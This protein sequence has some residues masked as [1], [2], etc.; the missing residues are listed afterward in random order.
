MDLRNL[1]EGDCG[2]ANPLIQLGSHFTRDA[3]YRDEGFSQHANTGPFNTAGAQDEMVKEFLGQV[4]SVP[5]T[6]HMDNLLQEMRAIEAQNLHQS[7]VKAPKVINEVTGQPDISSNWAND[8]KQN[9]YKP[10]I[11][12]SLENN[13]NQPSY[14]GMIAQGPR[15]MPA[16]FNNS[17]NL[18]MNRMAYSN[19]FAKHENELF[20]EKHEQS[21]DKVEAFF[22][23]TKEELQ[24]ANTS[25]NWLDDF[26]K[27]KQE[28]AE[29]AES[30]YDK[31]WTKLQQDWNDMAEYDNYP[32]LSQGAD[33]DPYK[34][35]EFFADNPMS[36]I[37]NPLEKGKEFL[38]QGDI[39]TAVLCFEA[40]VKQEPENV[41]AWEL[42]GLSQ[43]ENEMDPQAITALR[44]SLDI[45]PNNKTVLMALAVSYTNESL[46]SQALNM[47]AKWLHI[48]PK[49]SNL[50]PANLLE[51]GNSITNS[52]IGPNA[53]KD[54]Q[55]L[56]LE[57]V[58]Q[59]QTTV[60]PEIQE[61]LG[62]LFNL[63]SEYD[64][65]AD[66]FQAALSSN[67]NSSKTWNRLGASFANGNRSVEAVDAYKQAL[68]I[69]PGFIRAR[70][71][72]GII[73][74]N[75]KA[76]KE[77]AEHLLTALN[78]QA[79]SLSRS[80]LSENVTSRVSPMSEVIWSTLRM[81][82]ALMGR[83]DLK[84]AA[85]SRDLECLNHEIKVD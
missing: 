13:Y 81:V 21:S 5:Q 67:P 18:F 14:S 47:L 64:K 54:M 70:Y 61:A 85:H 60:D 1:L 74:M 24:S 34:E 23:P 27:N 6:F 84:K 59:N 58:K 37:E 31:F 71:N 52:L 82:F 30:Y 9:N 36:N 80:G 77:A 75:L 32:W 72:V 62:V 20:G 19:Q 55:N 2:G 76:Y 17:N 83:D 28:E 48:N 38:K 29:K 4:S 57:A 50:V 53:L 11:P 63:S 78:M 26:Q 42:L 25:E 43:A 49:Y 65:A 66:C 10:A 56:F 68:E 7:I 3:A 22:A 69:Q 12:Q 79:S 51:N 33:F 35:Y 40:A 73:C 45:N 44:K 15:S 41:E 16:L 39:P 46:Q 8:F